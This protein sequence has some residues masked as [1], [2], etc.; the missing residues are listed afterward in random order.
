M[1]K[2]LLLLLIFFTLGQSLLYG[3]RVLLLEKAGQN[4]SQKL[5]EGDGLTFRMKGDNFYQEGMISEL[6][7]DIQAMVINDRFILL[8]EVESLRFEGSGILN[9]AGLSLMTFGVGWSLFAAAGY[10]VDG[11]PETSYSG[12]D[13]TVSATSFATGFLLRKLFAR[14]RFKLN[15]RKRLRVVDLSF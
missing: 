9:Y 12:F 10:A 4:Q 14:R 6:R 15:D 13:L 8:N 5:Y 7:P 2:N 3:Q 1:L 11:N